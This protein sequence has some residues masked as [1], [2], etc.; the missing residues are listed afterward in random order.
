MSDAAHKKEK[1]KDLAYY[2]TIF[3]IR[4]HETW[5]AHLG[6]DT[7]SFMREWNAQTQGERPEIT[8]KQV[9]RLDRITGTF[10]ML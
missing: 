7:S 3:K 8:E 4:G 5:R 1:V 6:R 10:K 9:L 2:F